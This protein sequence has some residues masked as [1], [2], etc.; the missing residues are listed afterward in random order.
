MGKDFQLRALGDH[1]II[2]DFGNAIDEAINKRVI[3]L[4]NW[5]QTQSF[6]EKEEH[7]S[8]VKDVIPAYSSLTIIYDAAMIRKDHHVSSA[9]KFMREKVEHSIENISTK[10]SGPSRIV[11]MPV[12]YDLSLAPDLIA[13]AELKKNSPEEIVYL[14]HSRKYRVYMIGFL[15]GFAY[16]GKVDERISAPRKINPRLF[17][18]AGS[19]GI[20]GI[21]TGIY[22]LDSPGGWNIIGQTPAKLFD[23]HD[24]DPVLLRAGDEVEFTPISLEKFNE[25]KSMQ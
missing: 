5:W 19:V 6:E 17:V 25:L 2:I 1:A 18:P 4:F 7:F 23:A 12:C 24:D 8:Y 3:E 22:P 10:K 15:P 16:M 13:I 14:H 21:Q 20:A 11:R 9:F